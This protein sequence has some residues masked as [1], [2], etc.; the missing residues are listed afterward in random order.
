[1]MFFFFLPFRLSVFDR[2]VLLTHVLVPSVR[3]SQLRLVYGTTLTMNLATANRKFNNAVS[4]RKK[5][6]LK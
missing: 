5:H 6:I 3:S 4:R 2:G 1:M